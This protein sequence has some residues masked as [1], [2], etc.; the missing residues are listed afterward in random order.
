MP[1]LESTMDYSSFKFMKQNRQLNTK[2]IKRIELSLR[3]CDWSYAI[4]IIVDSDMN[5]IDGQHRFEALRQLNRPIY[6]IQV[7]QDDDVL[8]GLRLVNATQMPWTMQQYMEHYAAIGRKDYELLQ[9]ECFVHML[10]PSVW[11]CAVQGESIQDFKDG[12]FVFTKQK[13]EKADSL[14]T[15]AKLLLKGQTSVSMRILK[16]LIHCRFNGMDLEALA[17]KDRQYPKFFKKKQS[18]HD[19]IMHIQELYKKG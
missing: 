10:T 1:K 9:T 12:L 4:P 17:K 14:I 16:A 13:K 18:L 15:L 19:Y 11:L 8:L 7:P 2:H 6:Y 5:I 3:R